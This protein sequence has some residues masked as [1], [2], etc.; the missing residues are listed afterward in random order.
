M[1]TI[2][3]LLALILAMTLLFSMTACFGQ[4]PVAG[5][6]RYTMN[7]AEMLEASGMLDPAED[8]SGLFS[9]D[10]LLALKDVYLRMFDGLTMVIVLDLQRNHTYTMEMDEDAGR[11]AAETLSDRLPE[12]V[13]EM[14]AVLYDMPVEELPDFLAA[15]GLTLDDL[16][17]SERFSAE[18]MLGGMDL[19]PVCGAYTYEEGKLIL[20]PEDSSEPTVLTVELSPAELKVT[21]IE[22][23]DTDEEDLELLVSLLP[24]IFAK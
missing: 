23:R 8:D 15:Y 7:L 11:A 9:A 17:G 5:T 1:R 2:H 4:D 12:L 22:S 24:L 21:A 10:Q 13:P 3:R 16:I 18:E 20:T 14:L 19:E 6:W